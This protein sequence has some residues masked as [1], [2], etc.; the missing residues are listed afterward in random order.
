MTNQKW[1]LVTGG[2]GGIGQSLIEEFL[3]AG[4]S[5]IA[6]DIAFNTITSDSERSISLPIDLEQ[7]AKSEV[8]TNE[9]VHQIQSKTNGH[10]IDC[11]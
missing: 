11:N 1:A 7:I 5:V 8:Y 3:E 9:F 10:G 6:A 4:Y 2:A